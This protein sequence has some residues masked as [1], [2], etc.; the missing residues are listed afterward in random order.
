MQDHV[1]VALAKTDCVILLLCIQALLNGAQQAML[2]QYLYPYLRGSESWPKLG[3]FAISGYRGQVLPY[4]RWPPLQ[5]ELSLTTFP[6]S[7]LAA[8][9][10]PTEALTNFV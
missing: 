3:Q 10:S 7:V 8:A 1:E 4:Q 9:T 2:N 5:K 6:P